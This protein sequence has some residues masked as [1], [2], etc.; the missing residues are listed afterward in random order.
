MAIDF[1]DYKNKKIIRNCKSVIVNSGS[2]VFD[3]AKENSP[4]LCSH[5]SSGT[6][7]GKSIIIEDGINNAELVYALATPIEEPIDIP[8][9][10]TADGTNIVAV[11]TTTEPSELKVG[12]WKQIT[13][14][15]VVEETDNIT[16]TGSNILIISTGAEITQSGTNLVIGG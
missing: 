2:Y 13:P 15:E 7:N 9:I 16:Q 4:Y 8:E 14:E 3:D 5:Q 11:E 6:F 12:Y 1:I 10:N